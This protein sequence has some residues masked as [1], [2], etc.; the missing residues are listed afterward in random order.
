M[1]ALGS[2]INAR[3][4]VITQR[5]KVLLEVL[6]MED[7]AKKKKVVASKEEIISKSSQGV[8]STF[9]DVCKTPSPGGPVPIPYPN[10]AKSS[11]T[12]SGSKKV[13]TEGKEVL[14]KKASYEK[15]TGD[16]A[17]TKEPLRRQGVE[18]LMPKVTRVMKKRPI[19]V[20]VSLVVFV[21]VVWILLSNIPVTLKP[22]D[23]PSEQIIP[24]TLALFSL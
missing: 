16:E 14:P 9:P 3:A 8:T 7:E 4:T 23:L 13:K 6:S 10:I 1:S 18:G 15:S 24:N 19:W 20:I 5:N 22:V 2:L 12:S 17:P 21:L 11:E